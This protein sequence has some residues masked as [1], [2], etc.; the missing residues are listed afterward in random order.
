MH[1]LLIVGLILGLCGVTDAASKVTFDIDGTPVVDG[2]RF[3]PI[4]MWIYG[5][6][7]D[8]MA[9][10]HEH[11]VNTLVG[12]GINPGDLKLIEEHG[13]MMIPPASDAFLAAAKDSPALLG[14]Y[15]EDEP[16]EHNIKPEDLKA[17][18]EALKKKEPTHPIGVTH[19]QL[20]GPER[21][22]DSGHFTMTDVYPVTAKRT[23]P[24]DA[25]GRYA[26]QPKAVHGVSW[27]VFTFVQCFGG[28]DTD[29]G[30]WAQPLPHEVRFMAF[31][32]L[33]NRANGIFYFS[34]WPRAPITWAEVATTNRDIQRLVPWLLAKGEEKKASA[35]A[36]GV[37]VRAKK[38]GES[39]LILAANGGKKSAGAEMSVDGLG[40]RKLRMPFEAGREV[41]AKEGKWREAFEPFEV[42]VYWAG[43]EPARP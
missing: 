19:N 3:F 43:E 38:I 12:N 1:L 29:G 20:V 33:I 21:Y 40:E 22:K 42:R 27:P 34:Y 16:E 5:L 26:W 17:K 8:V 13:M 24:L 15:L 28:P 2:K 10:L 32:A 39:W 37:A 9:D 36:E 30:L 7:T 23:W 18:F 31:S 35:S 4:G 41:A 14:W 25:V 11:H 6:N